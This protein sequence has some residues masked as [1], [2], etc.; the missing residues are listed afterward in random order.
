MIIGSAMEALVT[1]TI[2]GLELA[3]LA[4]NVCRLHP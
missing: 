3:A 1:W 4:E 2:V